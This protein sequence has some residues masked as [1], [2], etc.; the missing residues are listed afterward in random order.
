MCWAPKIYFVEVIRGQRSRQK[1]EREVMVERNL[2]A[3]FEGAVPHRHAHTPPFHGLLLRFYKKEYSIPLFF[4]FL[5]Y[6]HQHLSAFIWGMKHQVPIFRPM[7]CRL[8]VPVLDRIIGPGARGRRD[9]LAP[10]CC[11]CRQELESYSSDEGR[12]TWISEQTWTCCRL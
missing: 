6:F 1:R 12:R 4:C 5:V 8:C 10:C 9:F 7:Y 11:L 2:K 3:P